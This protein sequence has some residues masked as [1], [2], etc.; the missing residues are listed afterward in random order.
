V[1]ITLTDEQ[2]ALLYEYLDREHSF[3]WGAREVGKTTKIGN[4][5]WKIVQELADEHGFV[6]EH[7]R[8][9]D[10]HPNSTP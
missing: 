4:R 7:E 2:F 8:A 10:A 6:P 9:G 1:A 3:V 5:L